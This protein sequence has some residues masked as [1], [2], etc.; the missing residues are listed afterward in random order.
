MWRSCG[1]GS[2]LFFRSSCLPRKIP[3]NNTFIF[4]IPASGIVR[5]RRVGSKPPQ[6]RRATI[7]RPTRQASCPLQSRGEREG[8]SCRRSLP[9]RQE[10]KQLSLSG[11]TRKSL[12]RRRGS[13]DGRGR[14]STLRSKTNDDDVGLSGGRRDDD[15]RCWLALRLL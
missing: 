3:S 10:P 14:L 8:R 6:A 2:R 11:R 1:G 15:D 13:S 9:L 5:R 4:L 7:I 12:R